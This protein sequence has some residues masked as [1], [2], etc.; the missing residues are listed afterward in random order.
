MRTYSAVAVLTFVI[1]IAGCSLLDKNPVAPQ[2]TSSVLRE[3]TPPD[4]GEFRI[5]D[6]TSQ[7][8][9]MV[10]KSIIDSLRVNVGIEDSL[11]SSRVQQTQAMASWMD[12]SRV[13][14][15]W[16]YDRDFYIDYKTPRSCCYRVYMTYALYYALQAVNKP[17]VVYGLS[18]NADGTITWRIIIGASVL[19][20]ISPASDWFLMWQAKMQYVG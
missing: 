3:A 17:L 11:A 13:R 6:E 1:G 19:R 18:C 14:Y 10:H 5:V 2:D 16:D 12:G 15:G 4:A 8:M 7:V 20:Y 9:V